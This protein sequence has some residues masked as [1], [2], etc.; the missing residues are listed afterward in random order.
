MEQRVVT[1]RPDG[2]LE[3]DVLQ[4]LWGLGEPASP[5]E[6]IEAMDTDL[7]YTSI[8]TVLGRLCE[9]DLA[10][11]KRHG[12]SFKY[13]A[14]NNEAELAAR[15]ITSIL[16]AAGDRASAIAG[17]AKSLDPAEAKQLAAL[18]TEQQ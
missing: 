3:A 17:F 18:L 2:A 9:K 16:D 4:A 14:T 5:A 11:R 7:A 10:E 6:V 12:R 8:A 13:R 1:K 15:R